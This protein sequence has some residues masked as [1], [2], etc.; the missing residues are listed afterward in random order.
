M[1][2]ACFTAFNFV[3]C[4]NKSKTA[5]AT[6]GD[7][8]TTGAPSEQQASKDKK[9]PFERG[10]YVEESNAMGIDMKKTVYFD[11]WGEWTA[12]EQK[13]EMEIIKNYTTKIHKL[14]IV[15]G[16]THWDLD[17]I[18]KTGTT[19]ELSVGTTGMA[20]AIGAAMSGKVME[21]TEIKD[22]GEED[23]LGYKCKKTQIKFAKMEMDATVLAYGNLTMKMDGKMGK[24]DISTK[25][26]SIDLNTPLPDAIFE[27][28]ADV[29]VTKN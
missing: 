14:E 25:I 8:K 13:M 26:T 23:Y 16:S 4:G 21:G 12:A 19:Y 11:K 27:V 18:K 2:I 28:P 20:A 6:T 22:L 29:V 9:L 10:S 15:K 1:I 3:S 17:L 24:M 7:V 5:A